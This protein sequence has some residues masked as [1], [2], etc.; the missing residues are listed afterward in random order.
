MVLSSGR[1][2]EATWGRERSRERQRKDAGPHTHHQ[3]FINFLS[4]LMWAQGNL[5][6]FHTMVSLVTRKNAATSYGAYGCH[7]GVGGKGAPKDAT[8]R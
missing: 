2:T 7:C 1:R 8:D 4:G 3:P 5:V 6:D